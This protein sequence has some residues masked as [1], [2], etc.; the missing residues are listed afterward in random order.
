M[1]TDSNSDD[2]DDS[3]INEITEDTK[4]YL[5]GWMAKKYGQQ[6]PELG[7]TKTVLIINII[8][9]KNTKQKVPKG[10]GVVKQLL[11]KIMNRM[12]IE[13]KYRPVI[14]TFVR[15]RIFIQMKY[16][17]KHQQTIAAKRK[18]NLQL[19]KLQKLRKLMT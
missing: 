7:C 4:E 16:A 19:K 17:N 9:K 15:Q 2:G 10:P 1:G 12:N 8:I 18:A 5:A 13:A 14:H 6:F 11:N 3:N